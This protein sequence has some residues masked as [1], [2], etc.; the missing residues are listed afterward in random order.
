MIIKGLSYLMYG[1]SYCGLSMHA[2]EATIGRVKK[3]KNQERYISSD[4]ETRWD[5][6]TTK[7]DFCAYDIPQCSAKE[8]GGLLEEGTVQGRYGWKEYMQS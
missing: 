8:G 3:R 6:R 4:C 2:L 1:R 7:K 5:Q